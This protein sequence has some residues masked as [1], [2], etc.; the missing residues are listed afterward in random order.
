[1]K[2]NKRKI[3]IILVILIFLIFALMLLLH[4]NLSGQQIPVLLYHHFLTEDEL[5]E[6]DNSEEY[7]VSLENFEKQM[8]YLYNNGYKS[9][10]L[11]DLYCFKKNE[12]NIP[13]KAFVITID[14]G[15]ISTYRYAKPILEKY[16][17]T[18][19]LFTISSR[20]EEENEDWDSTTLQYVD[21]SFLNADDNTIF[22]QSH[23]HDFHN[24][25]E[26]KKKIE[27]MDYNE[28]YNDLEK[29]KEILNAEYL[30]FPFNTYNNDAF[31][32]LENNNYKM[33][34]IGRNKKTYIN[35]YFYMTSRI[36]VNNDFSRF[37]S[38][39]ETDDFNQTLVD[40]VKSDL[41]RLKK[42]VIK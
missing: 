34:F 2:K 12:C 31:K 11:D 36:F 9:I 35:E 13:D 1:M 18:A 32:A 40:K 6:F 27:T 37:T 3:I 10:T 7:V 23:S 19:T 42:K 14:D 21:S 24:M 38:I 17:Y 16:G 25:V 20:V 15:L 5:S 28:I 41:L 8:E 33:A 39:F 22:I 4:Y 30:A 29:S 26:G